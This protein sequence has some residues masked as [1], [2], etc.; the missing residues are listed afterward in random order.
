MK[1]WYPIA[2]P[3][4]EVLHAYRA[5]LGTSLG[6]CR[7][8][9]ALRPI[10]A[11]VVRSAR[12]NEEKK[13]RPACES[14]KRAPNH[15]AR[16]AVLELKYPTLCAH[17]QRHNSRRGR[18]HPSPPRTQPKSSAPTLHARIG[19]PTGTPTSRAPISLG[20]RSSRSLRSKRVSG[21]PHR[22][23]STS[24]AYVHRGQTVPAG[25]AHGRQRASTPTTT[26]PAAPPPP[27]HQNKRAKTA[28][29]G[30][31]THNKDRNGIGDANPKTT[32]PRGTLRCPSN[33]RK[34]VKSTSV[35]Q[36]PPPTRWSPSH[37]HI[38]TPPRWHTCPHARAPANPKIATPP[39][40]GTPPARP[41]SAACSATIP[42]HTV[43]RTGPSRGRARRFALH[44]PAHRRCTQE[45][46]R[47]PR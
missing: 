5:R 46:G 10:P 31:N 6:G 33:Q 47:V 32:T 36:G 9:A 21:S 2:A 19:S 42:R 22:C 12:E 44:H 45:D 3:A 11:F 14:T 7:P 43:A 27:L 29:A 25:A 18:R 8:A 38:T 20:W 41:S 23:R 16:S 37:K 15:G 26:A 13:R 24:W 40:A 34:T 1:T 39:A 30:T 35:C 4:H 17:V 28:R